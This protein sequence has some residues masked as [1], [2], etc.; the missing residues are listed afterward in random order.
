MT[1]IEPLHQPAKALAFHLPQFHPNASNDEWWGKGFTEWTNVAKARPRFKGHHQPHLPGDLGFYDLR[2]AEARAAQSELALAHGLSGF[3]YYHYWFSGE[4][5]LHEPVQR[6]LDNDEPG[7]PFA[8]CWANETWSRR[9]DGSEHQVL[10]Q[11]RYSHEDDLVHI[12]HLVQT[13]SASRYFR[14]GGKP[15]FAV[16]DVSGLPE[17]R[18]TTDTWRAEADR[19]GVGEIFLCAVERQVAYDLDAL[20]FD[21]AIEFQPMSRFVQGRYSLPLPE[22][23]RNRLRPRGHPSRTMQLFDYAELAQVASAQG[24]DPY[25]RFPGVTP[26][27]DNSARRKAWPHIYVGS[28]PALYEAWLGAALRRPLTNAPEKLVFINAWNEWAEG[29]HLEPDSHDGLAYLEAT[30]RALADYARLT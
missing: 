15:L 17:P 14:I 28:T 18:R 13:F 8:L 4:R 29:N 30:A 9:W 19:L 26:A 24:Q 20:G 1:A 5:L 12:R 10:I 16:Y 21:A 25:L 2:L 22:R 3:L 11:Q 6:T 23:V 27:W 7:I